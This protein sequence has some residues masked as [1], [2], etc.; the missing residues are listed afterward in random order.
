MGTRMRIRSGDHYDEWYYS[1][2]DKPA[3]PVSLQQL[4]AELYKRPDWKRE[5][6]WHTGANNWVEAGA[7][8]E[9]AA[10]PPPLPI[11]KIDAA[12]PTS[13]SV[14]T[15]KDQ[16]KRGGVR[17][18][19]SL[20]RSAFFGLLLMGVVFVVHLLGIWAGTKPPDPWLDI[21]RVD[22]VLFAAH[23]IGYFLPAPILFVVIA[24][25]QNLFVRNPKEE[26]LKVH[27]G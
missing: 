14:I 22:P 2:N 6:V 18:R 24:L 10:T 25:I 23:W 12:P 13:S 17:K 15:P 21:T 16:P 8:P 11:K 3:G 5:L 7:L 27:G 1:E 26:T 20:T 4:K 9:L 19:W